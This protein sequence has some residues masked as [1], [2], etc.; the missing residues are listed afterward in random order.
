MM[1][2]IS[3][4]TCILALTL[5][6]GLAGCNQAESENLKSEL[7]KTKFEKDVIDVKMHELENIRD[8]LQKQIAE[9]TKSCEQLKAELAEHHKLQEQID[10]LTRS[11]TELK[12]E[13]DELAQKLETGTQKVSVL[14]TR[15][16]PVQAANA[17]LQGTIRL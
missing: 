13:N 1:K 5:P 17:E 14:E 12:K 15:L 9:L 7:E 2:Q 4:M 6:F 11:R 3:I 8:E 16:E 10:E